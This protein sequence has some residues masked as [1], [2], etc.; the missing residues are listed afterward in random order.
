MRLL[1]DTHTLLWWVADAPQLSEEARRR[2]SDEEND[3]F[4][5]LVSAWEMAIKVGTGKLKLAIS[6]G[7][8]FQQHLP[9]NA[10]QL[11]QIG[12]GH[13]TCLE[14]LPLH[15]RDPFDRLLIAQALQEPLTLVSIDTAFD[16]YGVPRIW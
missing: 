16:Q 11:L 3:C 4:V 10:F 8:Y 2:I 5:S 7:G 15:H 13:I 9:A 1:L 12:L 6:V 14:T